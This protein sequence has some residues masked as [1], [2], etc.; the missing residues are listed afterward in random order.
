MSAVDADMEQEP[1]QQ[2]GILQ[3]S[4]D[5]EI[6][7]DSESRKE[8]AFEIREKG[9]KVEEQVK[10]KPRERKQT[11]HGQHYSANMK[12]RFAVTF[13]KQYEEWKELTATTKQLFKGYMTQKDVETHVRTHNKFLEKIR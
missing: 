9:N 8:E 10:M 13:M 5:L 3:N 6:Q 11:E 7:V 4:G 2:C 1:T 12:E